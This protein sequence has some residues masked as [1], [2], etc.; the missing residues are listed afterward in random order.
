MLISVYVP[1]L[2]TMVLA[3]ARPV[4]PTGWPHARPPGRW[5]PPH[6]WRRWAGWVHWRYWRSPDWHRS[7]RSPRRAAGR[8]R[9]CVPPTRSTSRSPG[10]PRSP[11]SP[12]SR[13]SRSPPYVSFGIC[14]GPAASADSCPVTRSWR[15][16]TWRCR[17][18]SRCRGRRA[19]SWCRAGCCAASATANARRCS[20]TSGPTCA[21]ATISSRPSGA[22][23]PPRIPCY[24]RCPAWA[25][26]SWS[27]GPT[28]RP[29]GARRRSYGRRAC[30]G[31]GGAGRLGE[32]V[33]S[34]AGRDRRCGTA[35]GQGAAR[36]SSPRRALPFV[37]GAAL[38]VL[39]CASLADA[40]TDSEQ[41]IETAQAAVTLAPH[42]P[43]HEHGHLGE[44][45]RFR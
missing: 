38:L 5:P 18:R 29:R 13:V 40:A 21:A 10:P 3:G 32:P 22:S 31:P 39:C 16:W 9:P 25:A 8:S 4:P 24:D 14:A 7:P 6:W 23:P 15:S 19:G 26:S 11:C 27:A 33:P 36:P 45:V 28:R 35:A 2:I 44:P 43:C 41:M 12:P 42:G 20:P 1:L 17:R 37:A 30:R 34:G